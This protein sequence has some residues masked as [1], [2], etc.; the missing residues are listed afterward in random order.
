[1]RE[2]KEAE[3]KALETQLAAYQDQQKLEKEGATAQTGKKSWFS[4]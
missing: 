4:W 2:E 1:M 3:L